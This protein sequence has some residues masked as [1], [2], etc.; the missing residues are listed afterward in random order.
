MPPK[1]CLFYARSAC[2]NGAD[3]RFLH[4][5]TPIIFGKATPTTASAKP[6]P[7][8][9]PFVPCH[10]YAA[11]TC[12][13]GEAC[14][15]A[16]VTPAAPP[17]PAPATAKA[18][19]TATV[20]TAVEAIE[21]LA[22]SESDHGETMVKTMGSTLAV[23]FGAGLRIE[24]IVSAGSTPIVCIHHLPAHA[25]A[26][27]VQA[28]VARFG[29]APALAAIRMV[30][31]DGAA[32]ATVDVG[33]SAAAEALAA[34]MHGHHDADA[35]AA[36]AVTVYKPKTAAPVSQSATRVSCSWFAPTQMAFIET[37][38]WTRSPERVA[39]RAQGRRV[40]GREIQCKL[41]S[42]TSHRRKNIMVTNLSLATT[43]GDLQLVFGTTNSNVSL[44]KPKHR[45]D[46]DVAVARIV[47]LVG[48]HEQ[49][50][51]HEVVSLPHAA[52]TRVV[53][54]FR[55][56]DAAAAAVASFNMQKMRFL[57]GS[58][59]FMHTIVTADFRVLGGIYR[60]VAAELNALVA[61]QAD[62]SVRLRIFGGS[63]PHRTALVTLRITG[64]DRAEVAPLKDKVGALVRAEVVVA[65]DA[66]PL[67]S[68]FCA[69]DDGLAALNEIGRRSAAYV[70]CDR[71]HSQ[72]LVY[73]AASCRAA[74]KTLLQDLVGADAPREVSLDTLAW[75]SLMRGGLAAITSAF[76]GARASPNILRHSLT[77]HGAAPTAAELQQLLS[78]AAAKPA[79]A[80]AATENVTDCPVCLDV[81]DADALTTLP[82]AHSYCTSCFTS[83]LD[84][85]DTFPVLCLAADCNTALPLRLL[86]PA[87]T[88]TAFRDHVRRNPSQF[89][90]CHTPD[91]TTLFAVS[92]AAT[93]TGADAAVW[94]CVECLA[95]ICSACHRPSH[96]GITCA[97]RFA[98][99]ELGA[100]WRR[101][102]GV[103]QCENC[104][105]L[106]VKIDGCNHV[107]CAAC[108]AHSCWVCSK[109]FKTGPQTYDH[110]SQVHGGVFEDV[111]LD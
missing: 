87:L 41:V 54:R 96:E 31:V 9:R 28:L 42:G 80:T 67:W 83:Y 68:P 86:P 61:A 102:N 55:S 1:P 53:L 35:D 33:S 46:T 108:K 99:Q 37:A 92:G 73:G 59:L 51:G 5:K 4:S 75:R 97:A 17:K 6:P 103:K 58:P 56:V 91:C 89:A 29:A 81:P 10:F 82:C 84:S 38:G 74:A 77:L 94:T 71:P 8:S 44:Q 18:T 14:E 21:Q 69:T 85:V 3:C 11:G 101:D 22:I 39:A 34:A 57:Y 15:F 66:E 24:S 45:V 62:K 60:T 104:G 47:A 107:Q 93:G 65:A 79:T 43:S 64:S 7:A 27:L 30:P 100:D 78:S 25:T 40:R 16:H 23:T 98:E 106:Q 72:L 26:E 2:K 19:A 110:L 32:Y 52:K 109:V 95:T 12:T 76:P 50:D 13:R 20:D 111:G 48:S 90:S 49:L 88:T 36:L 63:K 105:V 70:H